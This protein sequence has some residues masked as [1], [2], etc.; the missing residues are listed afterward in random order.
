MFAGK[1]DKEDKNSAPVAPS[2]A[3]MVEYVFD[4][5]DVDR[6]VRAKLLDAGAR[7][8]I[9]GFRRGKA[10]L[11]FLQQ[12]FGGE[13]LREELINRAAQRFNEEQ[14]KADTEQA[15]ASPEMD[16]I[17]TA[18]QYAVRCNYE[19]MPEISAPDFS[20]QKLKRPVLVIGDAEVERM[21]EKLRADAGEYI[22]VNRPAADGD[23]AVVDYVLVEDGAEREKGENRGWILSGGLL[24]EQTTKAL[25]GAAAGDKRDITLPQ[26]QDDKQQTPQ[27]SVL[28]VEVKNISELKKAEMNDALFAKYGIYEGGEQA[29]RAGVRDMLDA[30][31]ASRL[32]EVL[33]QRAL[34]CLMAATPRFSLPQAMVKNEIMAMWREHSAQLQQMKMTAAAAN[35]NAAQ[36]APGAARRVALGLLLAA[37]RKRDNVEISDEDAEKRLEEL[38]GAYPSPEEF[39]ARAR[40]NKNEWQTLK[41]AMLEERA[42]EWIC[43]Q[44]ETEDEQI[45][46]E[47]LLG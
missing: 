44:A 37:W 1:K 3:R 11:N 25:I 40:N 32:R 28:H 21:I 47:H 27:E 41:L 26:V 43:A 35:I 8:D 45:P 20:G 7:M 31:V 36:F 39:R 9:R 19:V 2:L 29:F 23:M 18:K 24:G 17:T 22:S 14:T 38:S 12:R 42:V 13:F 10:P 34:D 46:M 15:A 4:N 6:T 33:N 16:A 30:Q 5:D